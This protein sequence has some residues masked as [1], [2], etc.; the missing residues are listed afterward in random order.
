MA[1]LHQSI[2]QVRLISYMES[3]LHSPIFRKLPFR[4]QSLNRS[5]V[6]LLRGRFDTMKYCNVD[7]SSYEDRKKLPSHVNDSL[8]EKCAE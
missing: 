5:I 8:K 4:I 1:R 6:H 2:Q 7:L 3:V